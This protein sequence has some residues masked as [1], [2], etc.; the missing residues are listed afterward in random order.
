MKQNL[1]LGSLQ[2]GQQ[3]DVILT[4]K[5]PLSESDVASLN[6]RVTCTAVGHPQSNTTS[7]IRSFG[8]SE[9]DQ[10]I[11]QS[12][13]IE[14]VTL[15]QQVIANGESL[16][17]STEAI[18]HA[19]SKFNEAESKDQYVL[20]LLK[21]VEGQ[22]S[23]ATSKIEW[24]RKWGRHYLPSLLGA[25][26][27]QQCNNFKDP[28]IQ[29]YGGEV[30]FGLRDQ[31]DDI[32]LKLPPPKPTKKISSHSYAGSSTSAA[33]PAAPVNMAAYYNVGGG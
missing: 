17:T 8:Q 5:T 22:I 33:Q 16:K 25:H 12:L 19:I 15:L 2:L 9:K 23:E 30:F 10:L 14:V 6:A 32:F 26:L 28:G 18:T 1:F 21:D 7:V 4:F 24:Y 31:I 20:D 11:A 29:H 3:K 13:R 27:F